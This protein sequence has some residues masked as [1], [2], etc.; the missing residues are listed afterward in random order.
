MSRCQYNR[1]SRPAVDM[2]APIDSCESSCASISPILKLTAFAEPEKLASPIAKGKAASDQACI[3]FVIVLLR[4]GD[5]NLCINRH[6]QDIAESVMST[7]KITCPEWP[8]HLSQA[9]IHR[10]NVTHQPIE[11]RWPSPTEIR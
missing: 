9:A 5:M 1:L 10:L 3:F 4:L 6:V 2:L 11:A 7:I 8:I